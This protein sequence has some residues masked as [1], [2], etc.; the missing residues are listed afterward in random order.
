MSLF[1]ILVHPTSKNPLI[2]DG[3]GQGI[4]PQDAE[5]FRIEILKSIPVVLPIGQKQTTMS[6]PIHQTE[7]TV[8][9]YSHHYQKDAESF[10]Y[11]EDFESQVDQTEKDRLNQTILHAI[12]KEAK[13]VLD[14]GC[15]NGWL[16][17]NLVSD[18]VQVISMDI[19]SV[20]PVKALADLPHKNH[21]GLIA[22]VFHLPLA[23]ESVDCIVASEIIEHVGHPGQFI[24]KLLF[25]LKKG[26]RLI[27]TTP[28]DE[29]IALHLCV[30]CNHLTP[31]HGHLH[32]FNEVSIKKYLPRGIN[33]KIHLFSNKYGSK[34]RIYALTRK[35]SYRIWRKM[36][37]WAHRILPSPM[38]MMVTI[39]K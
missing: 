35:W 22:D 21:F 10:N 33:H 3:S 34:L 15:G 32:S 20:N 28:Y 18:T 30:H 24:E 6:S 29:K 11:F 26:G 5:N 14:V 31:A 2:V 16:S 12:P 1:E 25:A 13:V 9:D 8:F 39:Q 36:D 23:P 37:Q 4:G 17:K 38:R 19:S 27:I 7:N